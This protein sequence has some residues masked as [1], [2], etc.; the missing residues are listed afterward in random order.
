MDQGTVA[1]KKTGVLPA[2]LEAM[3]PMKWARN[4][5]VLTALIF[6]KKVFNLPAVFN[7]GVAFVLFC[8]VASGVYLVNDLFDMERDR[9]HP[10]KCKRPLASGRL[11]VPVAIVAA[12]VF[13][14]VG[15]GIGFAMRASLGAILLVYTLINIA[16]SLGLKHIVLVDTFA[17]AS[18]YVLRVAAGAAAVVVERF[19]PWLYVFTLFLAMLVSLAKRRQELL[20]LADNAGAHRTSLNE[21]TKVFFDQSISMMAC[22]TIVVYSLY[23]F[24]A[25]NLPSDHAM[26]LTIPLA[27]FAFLRYLFLVFSRD[28]GGDPDVLLW[29]DKPLVASIALWGVVAAAVLY[30]LK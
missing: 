19:S 4:G 29:T 12:I 9:Q 3:R 23:T 30:W 28:E 21:Y 1:F 27:M 13:L 2:L 11:P 17:V 14:G 20:M 24:F 6:D 25:P 8:L 15:V 22:G 18:G 26:M 7:A 5:F 16:Y 10:K